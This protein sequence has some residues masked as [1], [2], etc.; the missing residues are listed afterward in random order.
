MRSQ[1]RSQS[2]SYFGQ[3]WT[4]VKCKYPILEGSLWKQTITVVVFTSAMNNHYAAIKRNIMLSTSANEKMLCI[5]WKN[6]GHS[7]IMAV[8]N[9]LPPVVSVA[10][11]LRAQK[12][13]PSTVVALTTIVIINFHSCPSCTRYTLKTFQNFSNASMKGHS[14]SSALTQ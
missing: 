8:S 4:N 9:E 7:A 10:V 14:Q 11:T 2:D 3:A 12:I 5:N 13:M 1:I 6:T